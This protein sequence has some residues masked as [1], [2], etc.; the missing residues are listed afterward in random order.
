M[1]DYKVNRRTWLGNISG[2]LGAAALA[3]RFLGAQEYRISG[4]DIKL[5]VASYSFRKFDRTQA[6]RMLKAIRTPY[7]THKYLLLKLDSSTEEIEAAKK[8]FKPAGIVLVACGNVSF[9]KPDE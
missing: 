3:P 1:S 4:S 2:A 8:K 9:Q 7:H 6:I 5:G